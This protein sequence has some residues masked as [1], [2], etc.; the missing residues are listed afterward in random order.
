[1]SA[2]K[3]KQMDMLNGPLLKKILFFVNLREICYRRSTVGN[4]IFLEL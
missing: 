1:M 3:N 2:Q 4:C